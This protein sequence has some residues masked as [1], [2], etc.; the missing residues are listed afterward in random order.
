MEEDVDTK[1]IMKNLVF[2]KE[3]IKRLENDL[4]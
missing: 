1:T 4:D 3:R 2:A